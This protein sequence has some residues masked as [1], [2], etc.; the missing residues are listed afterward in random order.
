MTGTVE[1][2]R[3]GRIVVVVDGYAPHRKDASV[4]ERETVGSSA[5]RGS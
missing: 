5:G 3:T 4:A 1:N 2:G